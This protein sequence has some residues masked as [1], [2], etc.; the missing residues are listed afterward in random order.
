MRWLLVAF[1][2]LHGLVH[3]LG[4]AKAFSLA[5]LPQLT[6]PISKSVGLVWLAAALLVLASAAAFVVAPR[7]FWVVGALAAVVSEVVIASAWRDAK[8]GTAANVMILF[9][10]IWSFASEGPWS[11]RAAYRREC[12]AALAR[13]PAPATVVDDDLRLLPEPVRN[14]VRRSGAVGQPQ[15]ADFRASW[16]GRIRGGETE[17]WMPFRAEQVNVYDS[18]L[19][20][21]LFFMDATMKHLPVDVFHR[22]VGEAATF[23]V[24]LLSLVQL[25][26]AKGPAMNRG[27]TV[28]LFN[29][30]CLLAPSRLIDRTIV[31]EAIDDHRARARYTRG[32]ETIAAELV[33]DAAFDL[34]DFVSDD[35]LAASS[36]GKTFTQ[37]RWTTPVRGYRAIGPRRVMS[38]GEARWETPSGGFA[39]I[40]LELVGLEVNGNA[41]RPS[42]AP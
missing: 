12:S 16:R 33:F 10:A 15:V 21:R 2:V 22:F 4:V 24:R 18:P 37:R 39:Y 30:L 11:M 40:E 13:A 27:E 34:V 42:A 7:E 31:W 35:R 1:I 20:S 3:L 32:T 38:A 36:D 26:D 14:Y 29:D 25:V 41:S 19:P 8:F 5:A 6:Q 9:A 23:R 28:T 17:P